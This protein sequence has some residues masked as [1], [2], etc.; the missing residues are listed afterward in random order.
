MSV[1]S[2]I[3]EEDHILEKFF[4]KCKRNYIFAAKALL[5]KDDKPVELFLAQKAMLLSMQFSFFIVIVASRG[6]GKCMSKFGYVQNHRGLIRMNELYGEKILSRLRDK[7]EVIKHGKAKIWTGTQLIDTVSTV[8]EK[9][10]ETCKYYTLKGYDAE[11]GW[12]KHKIKV[13]NPDSFRFEWK[14]ARKLEKDDIIPI[15]RHGVF[16]DIDEEF[17]NPISSYFTGL[18]IGNNDDKYTHLQPTIYCSADKELLRFVENYWENLGGTVDRDRDYATQAMYTYTLKPKRLSEEFLNEK[19]G[20]NTHAI[21]SVQEVPIKIRMSTKNSIRSFLRGLFDSIGSI[22]IKESKIIFMFNKSK[23]LTEQV[24]LLLLMFGVTSTRYEKIIDEELYHIISI[25]DSFV[26][27]FNEEIGFGLKRKSNRLDSNNNPNLDIVPGLNHKIAKFVEILKDN[28][29]ESISFLKIDEEKRDRI[30][31]IWRKIYKLYILDSE[32]NTGQLDEIIE[33]FNCFP[34]IRRLEDFEIVKTINKNN[35]SFDKIIFTEKSNSDCFDHT[36]P[37][38]H[39]YWGNGAIQH[40]TFIMAVFAVLKCLLNTR[41]KVGITGPT[42][43]QAKFVFAEIQRLYSESPIVKESCKREPTMGSDMCKLEFKNGSFIFALPLGDGEK[44]RGARFNTMLVDEAVKVPQDILERSILPMMSTN[45]SPMESVKQHRL[46]REA[47]ARGENPDEIITGG[48]KIV[49]CTSAW[50]QIAYLYSTL[51]DW[52]DEMEIGNTKY[53]VLSFSYLEAPEGF[54]DME[55]V[56]MTKKTVSK[57]KFA[58]EWLAFWPRDTEGFFPVSLFE[59]ARGTFNIETH[60]KPG[61]KYAISIDPA[62]ESDNF[63]IMTGKIGATTSKLVYTESASPVNESSLNGWKNLHEAVRKVIRDFNSNGAEVIAI[64]LDQGGGG[65]IIRD[66]LSEEYEWIDNE[67][68]TIVEPKILEIEGENS[69]HDE[70]FINSGGLRILHYKH[71]SAEWINVTAWQLKSMLEKRELLFPSPIMGSSE[72]KKGI[73]VEIEETDVRNARRL[74]KRLLA[75]DVRDVIMD[76]IEETIYECSN[77]V[78]TELRTKRSYYHF[79]TIKS[80]LKKDRWAALM[81]LAY[82]IYELKQRNLLPKRDLAET[83]LIT[84]E[85]IGITG[86]SE[87]SRGN[88]DIFK[89]EDEEEEKNIKN[90]LEANKMLNNSGNLGSIRFNASAAALSEK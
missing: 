35:Y 37:Y 14:L 53:K 57:I 9:N 6:F 7:E 30:K 43:R 80:S 47:I 27:V 45:K 71:W 15:Q 63:I 10:I 31:S 33:C 19:M 49:L 67:G 87:S 16:S 48:N 26:N 23:T 64:A 86:V 65:S 62:R 60:G 72:Y 29:R 70:V 84:R 51:K 25:R 77:V 88:V 17:V 69:L 2:K 66:M 68:D 58:M 79:S 4:N 74:K 56:K 61:E 20:V 13:W 52:K 36:I 39:C 34:K 42:Y 82:V 78:A 22:E 8:Y 81:L 24:H 40:N 75:T 85:I 89:K 54:F 73:S 50:F 46:R 90:L 32:I 44:I 55:F 21:S 11:V 1:S 76:D 3:R 41:E 59:N 83:G 38:E 18:M 28:N 5:I 12:N